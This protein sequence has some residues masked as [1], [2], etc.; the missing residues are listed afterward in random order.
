MYCDR[1][2]LGP[3]AVLV[4]EHPAGLDRGRGAAPLTSRKMSRYVSS[5]AIIASHGFCGMI[6]MP[7]P[8]SAMIVLDSGEMAAA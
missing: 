6:R 1:Q 2:L 4:A 7:T 3:V 8:S 5:S